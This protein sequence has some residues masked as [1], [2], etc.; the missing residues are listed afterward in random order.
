MMN[1]S[2]IV[3]LV[4]GALGLLDIA[5]RASAITVYGLTVNN[6]LF[7]F[8]AAT[9][10]VTTSILPITGLGVTEDVVGIDFRPGTGD[11][12]ALGFNSTTE[13]ARLYTVNESTGSAS[14]VG[15]GVMLP[16]TAAAT[17]FG[18]DFSHRADKL[19]L[20]P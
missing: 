17:F 15:P 14:A 3:I 10:G 6:G 11:L 18:F 9:P 2:L 5:P 1:R 4:S 7:S 19:R 12:Y 13:V 16:G 20:G 8:D